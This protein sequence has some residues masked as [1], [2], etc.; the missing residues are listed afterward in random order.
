MSSIV[1]HLK[2]RNAITPPPYVTDSIQYEVIMGSVAYGVSS[3]MSDVDVYGFCI[4]YKDMVFPH[5]KGVIPGFGRQQQRFDQFQ[6]HHIKDP[7]G[8]NKEYD[9][10][11]YSIIKYFQLCMD[12]NPNMIDSLFVPRRCV[13]YSSQIGELIRENRKLFLHKGAFHKF[14]KYA[15]SQMHKMETKTIKK[16]MS[17]CDCYN[18]DYYVS[19][20]EGENILLKNGNDSELEEF[21]KLC[22]IVTTNGKKTKR[23]KPISKYGY[24]V[25]FAYHIVR[26]L[27][28]IEQILIEN[29]IDLEKNREQLKSIRRGEWSIKQ[30]KEYFYDKE[31]MLEEAYIKSKLPHKPDEKKI[32]KLLLDCLEQHFGNLNDYTVK[33]NNINILLDDLST[34]INKY[35]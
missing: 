30:I 2:E 8:Q 34:L 12:N 21:K 14:K 6:Q 17:F 16:F 27:S 7:S 19:I 32:K 23:I 33:E 3:D 31:K 24:D 26:L 10:S 25:K 18:L 5:L 9:L 4:P 20:E 28:E 35:R 22:K 15:Y 13:L 29:D 11:I 1:K